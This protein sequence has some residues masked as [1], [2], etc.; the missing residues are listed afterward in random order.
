MSPGEIR[1][2]SQD[3]H[4]WARC[5]ACPD[6]LL[7]GYFDFDVM[8]LGSNVFQIGDVFAIRRRYKRIW[9]S[10]L[11][12]WPSSTSPPDTVIIPRLGLPES[13]ALRTRDDHIQVARFI[14]PRGHRSPEFKGRTIL[15]MVDESTDGFFV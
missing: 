1:R 9:R 11:A 2:R 4:R 14:C 13:I 6:E 15:R 7:I 8:M 3:P 10:N 5:E 12:G